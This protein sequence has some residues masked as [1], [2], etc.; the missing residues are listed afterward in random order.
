M[1]TGVASWSKTAASNA[2]ADSNVNWAEGQA[3]SSVNNS[4]RAEMA[5]VAMWRDDISG[6][7]TTG[8]TSTAYTLTT[9]QSFASSSAMDGAMI[10][11][12]PHATNGADP[13][14]AVDGLTARQIVTTS[15]VN[16]GAGQLVV[17]RV[18]VVTYV[19]SSTEFRLH[20]A[21]PIS[22]SGMTAETALAT[23]DVFPFYDD[24]AADNRKVTVP[25]LFKAVSVLDAETAP[26]T[27]DLLLISD[28]SEGAA[29]NRITLENLLKVVNALTE[30]T[31]PDE[32]NDF[33][34]SYDASASGVKKV[35]P[36]NLAPAAG[37]GGAWVLIETQAASSSSTIDLTTGFD[38][39]Y[40]AYEIRITNLKV[41]VDDSEIKMQIGTGGGPTFQSGASDYEWGNFQKTATASS[42][43][44][45]AA[46]SDMEI[47]ANAAVTGGVGNAAGEHLS[48]R[49]YFSN[50][51]ASDFPLFSWHGA[52]V[53]SDGLH[54]SFTGGGMYQTAGAITGI[55]FL[56][57]S[58]NFPSGRIA[59][60]G[61][62]KA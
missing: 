15:G 46:D 27:D 54:S 57:T 29:A 35:K 61:L 51:E 11:F 56:P 3:P 4:A 59:L 10:A 52:Y 5:S 49:I 60:Y 31:S 62:K 6:T 30:D 40:D 20:G 9:N 45:D 18:H 13:T 23:A 44:G 37:Q 24:S 36:N 1:A 14:L 43:T 48:A 42:E 53:R 22:I 7:L 32:A 38:D 17:G 21:F 26:A 33:L 41:S 8:G 2:T 16:V 47:G 39:T 58:G 55:R 50:P 34:L 12:K 28:S 19:N 25:N